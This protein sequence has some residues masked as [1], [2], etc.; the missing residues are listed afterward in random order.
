MAIG[1]YEHLLLTY[2]T[3]K[4]SVVWCADTN[5]VDGGV[6]SGRIVLQTRAT[7]Q[8]WIGATWVTGVCKL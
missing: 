3:R 1:A 7:I 5:I 8:T 4:P 6:R 2:F